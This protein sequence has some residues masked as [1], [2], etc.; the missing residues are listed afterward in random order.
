VVT[1]EVNVIGA[2]LQAGGVAFKVVA[3]AF[4]LMASP[5]L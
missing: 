4:K 2:D 5:L 3:E 1:E